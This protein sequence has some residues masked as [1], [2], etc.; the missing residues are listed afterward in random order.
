MAATMKITVHLDRDDYIRLKALARERGSSPA[1]LL[2]EAV[3]SF[4]RQQTRN[5]RP[6]S[7]SAGR[8]GRGDLSRRAE[9]LLEGFGRS[10]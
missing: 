8:S 3:A 9:E 1:A 5:R 4:V 6:R 2:R 10:S 7:L